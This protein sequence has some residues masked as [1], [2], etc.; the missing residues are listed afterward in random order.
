[1]IIDI[2]IFIMITVV[3]NYLT[4]MGYYYFYLNL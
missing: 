1:M 3:K 4:P 2:M